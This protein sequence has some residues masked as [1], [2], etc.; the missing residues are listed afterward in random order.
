MINC[1]LS[2]FDFSSLGSSLLFQPLGDDGVEWDAIDLHFN[3]YMG[4]GFLGIF[5]SGI[6]VI[7][8]ICFFEEFDVHGSK[9]K[10]SLTELC[11]CCQNHS[12]ESE[13][14]H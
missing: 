11:N 1:F 2:L 4:P 6:T 5:L 3:L 10:K 14:K 9:T 7:L 12:Q 8:I 13:R